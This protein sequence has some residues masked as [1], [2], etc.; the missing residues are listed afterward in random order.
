MERMK[1][2]K[3]TASST[4]T[5]DVALR[6][7]AAVAVGLACLL[8]TAPPADARIY[9]C[10]SDSGHISFQETTCDGMAPGVAPSAVP[11]H[12]WPADGKHIFWKAE[13]VFGTVYLLGSL[14]F[15]TSWIYPLPAVMTDALA[16]SDALVVEANVTAA[17]SA[18]VAATL[19]SKGAYL[20]G[21]GLKQVVSS[22]T[23]SV[24]ENVTR[25]L[26]LPIAAVQRQKPWLASMTLTAAALEQVGYKAEQGVD[27]HLMRTVGRG[28]P[29]IELES[30]TQQLEL[31]DDIPQEDQVAMLMQTLNEI[32]EADR[33][34]QDLLSTW[35]KGDAEK[36]GLL[37]NEGFD[38]MVGGR[39]LYNR[40]IR[41]RNEAMQQKIGRLTRAHGDIFV[42][43]GAG[44]LV[45]DEGLVERMKAE[46]YEIEQL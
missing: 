21:G 29:I 30:V 31:L 20:G 46:G 36:L 3:S 26:G 5:F 15:G 38:R 40:L 11:Q 19:A 32:K 44:H 7:F 4:V 33:H 18:Q 12:A 27:I 24:V 14:H 8:V 39:R 41:D 2:A 22:A 35:L 37:L 17:S 9:K 28:K 42:V 6:R 10:V 25:T 45:G 13:S 43:V 1:T 16:S 23:W 34:F